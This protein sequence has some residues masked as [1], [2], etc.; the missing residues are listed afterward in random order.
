MLKFVYFT[1]YD[2][3]LLILIRRPL[4]LYIRNML[5]R[6]NLNM[7]KQI[8]LFINLRNFILILLYFCLELEE[9]VSYRITYS[10]VST[11]IGKYHKTI[12]YGSFRNIIQRYKTEFV[13][14]L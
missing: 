3:K 13:C 8:K 5:I 9:I 1:N 11:K 6:F 12:V 10:T 2:V 14:V 7:W 4:H